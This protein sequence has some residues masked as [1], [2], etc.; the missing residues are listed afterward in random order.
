VPGTPAGAGPTAPATPAQALPPTTNQSIG[1]WAQTVASQ[2]ALAAASAAQEA[3]R[4]A[5]RAEVASHLAEAHARVEALAKELNNPG[6]G[7]PGGYSFG[8]ATSSQ[9]A[10]PPP[11]AG[12]ADKPAEP[13][14]A[15]AGDKKDDDQQPCPE[16]YFDL[17][18]CRRCGAQG[19]FRKG[20]CVNAGC[21]P[22]LH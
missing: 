10:P 3:A 9:S 17:R 20:L 1:A 7:T 21:A 18:K 22:W 11:A 19:Y 6:T 8:G 15:P 13:A 5:R 2:A 12:A 16:V 4:L 14:A